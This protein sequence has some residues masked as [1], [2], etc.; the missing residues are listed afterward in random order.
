MSA[1]GIIAASITNQPRRSVLLGVIDSSILQDLLGTSG[2]LL[3]FVDANGVPIQ[4][5]IVTP[6]VFKIAAII[7]CVSKYIIGQVYLSPTT[8]SHFKAFQNAVSG[9]FHD[10]R[11]RSPQY[12]DGTDA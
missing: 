8:L 10:N 2:A 3:H 11:S 5:R 6:K 1:G 7:P 4:I 12:E 9:Y